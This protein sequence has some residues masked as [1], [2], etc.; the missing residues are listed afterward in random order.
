MKNRQERKIKGITIEIT[1]SKK[2]KKSIRKSERKE[3]RKGKR[4]R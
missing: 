4:G 1:G 3:K 2:E